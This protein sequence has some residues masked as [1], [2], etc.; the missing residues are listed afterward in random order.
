MIFEISLTM[1]HLRTEQTKT[2]LALQTFE[3]CCKL[4]T[5]LTILLVDHFLTNKRFLID[6]LIFLKI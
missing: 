6:F 5:I 2:S 4:F 1:Q 3:L